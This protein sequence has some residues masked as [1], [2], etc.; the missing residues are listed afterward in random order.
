MFGAVT[1][2]G[3]H[4]F[5]AAE[6][7]ET[8]TYLKFLGDL[9]NHFG[10][11]SVIADRA[12]PHKSKALMDF[13]KSNPDIQV[14]YLPKGCPEFNSV[15]EW[16]RRAKHYLMVSEYYKTFDEMKYSLCEYF[17]TRKYPLNM[18]KYFMRIMPVSNYLCV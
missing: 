6:K 5:R 14:I 8:K 9:Q 3:R 4:F 18:M 13:L 12:I 11:I 2:D 7:F 17:R 1:T 16:W 10:K 15:E